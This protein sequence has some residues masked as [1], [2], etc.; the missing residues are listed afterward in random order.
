MNVPLIIILTLV[1]KLTILLLTLW[2]G[3]DC[4]KAGSAGDFAD[5]P[6]VGR[7]CPV[8]AHA[9]LEEEKEARRQRP[10]ITR[11]NYVLRARKRSS[12][13]TQMPLRKRTIAG[14]CC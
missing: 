7:S 12:E 8:L 6:T 5:Q 13:R 14:M 3:P 2:S 4:P 10:A 1:I 9:V 11:T